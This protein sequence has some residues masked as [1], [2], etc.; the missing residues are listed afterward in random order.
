MKLIICEV[1]LEMFRL[2]DE[3][4]S[5]RCGASWGN[6]ISETDAEYGGE[7]IPIGI[8]N[9]DFMDAIR[10]FPNE[11]RMIRCWV[12]PKDCQTMFKVG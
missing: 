6:Y 1:C 5:C 8:D 9:R 10:Y 2:G 4:R 11:R 12:M 7:A 3:K